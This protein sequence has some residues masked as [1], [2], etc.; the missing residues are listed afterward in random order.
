LALPPWDWQP[1]APDHG[2]AYLTDPLAQTLVMAGSG[3]VDLWL[4]SIAADSDLQV[5]LSEVR[6]DGYE[7][8]VQSGWLRASHR[9]LDSA[10]STA[11]RPVHTHL[12]AD[13]ADLPAGQFSVVR[14]ELFPFAHVFRVGSRIRIV[15]DS[16]GGTRPLWKFD[17]LMP[18]QAVR[19]TIGRSTAA[20]SR[21]VLPVIPDVDVETPLPPCPSLRGQPCRPYVALANEEGS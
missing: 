18:E 11:L 15:I 21:I 13:A 17:V 8:F 10:H 5:T 16:P 19:N 14:V 3:S 12:A 2:L 20:A 1:D 9:K 4:K 6:P 7:T